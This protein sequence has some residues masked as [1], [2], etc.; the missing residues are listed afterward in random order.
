M[1][2]TPFL[3]QMTFLKCLITFQD[4]FFFM[5]AHAKNHSQLPL[6]FPLIY[7]R[8]IKFWFTPP[9]RLISKKQLLSQQ[10]MPNLSSILSYAFSV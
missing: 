3:D 8:V 7:L 1:S 4:I 9:A 2:E 5:C 6:L 10:A